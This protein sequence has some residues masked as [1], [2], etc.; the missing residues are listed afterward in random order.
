VG[1]RGDEQ[2]LCQVLSGRFGQ[3]SAHSPLKARATPAK[4]RLSASTPWRPLSRWSRRPPNL[5]RS[6]FSLASRRSAQRGRRISRTAGVI[7]AS[8][9]TTPASPPRFSARYSGR[10]TAPSTWSG[11]GPRRPNEE[12]RQASQLAAFFFYCWFSVELG[13][14]SW[15]KLDRSSFILFFE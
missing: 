6:E 11:T 14:H 10:K 8:S 1:L 15:A 3:S 5:P 12:R 7:S 13:S 2:A 4:S 9:S